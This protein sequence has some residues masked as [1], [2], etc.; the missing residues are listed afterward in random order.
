MQTMGGIATSS[1]ALHLGV[2]TKALNI[3]IYT[4]LIYRKLNNI[5]RTGIYY[6]TYEEARDMLVYYNMWRRDDHVPNSY[7][8]PNPTEI[9]VAIDTAI[10]C[11]SEKIGLDNKK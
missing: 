3:Q 6:M 5:I 8:Q 2:V 9:G 7:K 11:L 4:T 1:K 10:K